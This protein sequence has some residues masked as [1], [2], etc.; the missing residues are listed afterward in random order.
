MAPGHV[1]TH[2]VAQ[3]LPGVRTVSIA[4]RGLHYAAVVAGDESRIDF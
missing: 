1:S 3:L 2:L 4:E